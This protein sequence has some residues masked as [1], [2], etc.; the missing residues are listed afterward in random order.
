VRE[1]VPQSWCE[2]AGVQAVDRPKG[3]RIAQSAVQTRNSMRARGSDALAI[4][5]SLDGIVRGRI[6]PGG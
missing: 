1:R 6:P 3:R 4:R 2:K 5:L